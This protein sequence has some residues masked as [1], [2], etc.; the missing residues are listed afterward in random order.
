MGARVLEVGAGAERTPRIVA[1]QDHHPNIAVVFDLRQQL[2]EAG[3]VVVTPSIARLRPAQGDD[4]DGAALVVQQRHGR[5]LLG[6]QS[7]NAAD[8]PS[9]SIPMSSRRSPGTTP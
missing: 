2:L 5:F 6:P 9:R 1:G 4:A 7:C 3:I 8:R